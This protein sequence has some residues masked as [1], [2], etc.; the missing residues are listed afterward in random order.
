MTVMGC[1]IGFGNVF[2]AQELVER[3]WKMEEEE[4]SQAQGV[5]WDVMMMENGQTL[6]M[7]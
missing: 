5:P 1:A 2:E 4:G 6:I 7:S 3:V